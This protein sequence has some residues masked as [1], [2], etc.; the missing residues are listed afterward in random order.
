[1]GDIFVIAE[2]RNGEIRDI[3]FEMLQKAALL[4]QDLS[5]QVTAVLLVGSRR[6]FCEALSK[7]ADR[8]LVYED[9]RLKTYNSDLYTGILGALV[10]KEQPFL[11]LMGI[12][13]G[14]W[15]T[16]PPCR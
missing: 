6:T 3:T 14:A 12:R 15:I 4:A 11:T 10:K 1:M 2:H 8:V 5:C 13:P 9:E 16:Q 7:W